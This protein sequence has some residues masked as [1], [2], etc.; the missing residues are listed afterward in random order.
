LRRL[1]PIWLPFLPGI[2]K[3]SKESIEQLIDR[4]ISGHT[5]IALVW[6]GEKARAL[7]GM[8]YTKRGDDLVGEIVWLTGA[9][10]KEWRHLLP[11]MQRY[12]KEHR[13]CAL[14][15]PICRPG[16]ARFLKEQGFRVT[17]FV[18]EREL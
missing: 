18:M 2:C 14:M 17:H 11:Q 10:M 3:R 8:L 6:D 5:E 9:G 4:I 16:W 1:S 12:L 15:R 13:H 7:V